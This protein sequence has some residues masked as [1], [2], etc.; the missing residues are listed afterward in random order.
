MKKILSAMLS[1][2][3]LLCVAACDN[4]P[5]GTSSEENPSEETSS[6][7]TLNIEIKDHDGDGVIRVSCVGDSITAGSGNSTYPRFLGDYLKYHGESVDGKTYEVKNHG[8]GGAAVRRD[9]PDA[10][11]EFWYDSEQYNGSLTYNSDVVIVQMGTNDGAYENLANADNYFKD[12]YKAMIKPY[13]DRNVTVVLA[14]PPEAS[15][16]IHNDGVNGKIST[17]VREIAEELK[18]PLVDMNVLTAGR[19]ESFPDGLHGN[20]S[21]YSLIAQMYYKHVF[22]GKLVTATINTQAGATVE[23][24]IN[25]AVANEQGVAK[26]TMIDQVWSRN[27][28]IEITC[29]GY[30]TINDSII[31]NSSASFNFPMTQGMYNVTGDAS[32]TADSAKGE[33][34]AQKAIDGDLSTRWESE[35]HDNA[36]LTVDL[37]EVKKINGVNIVWEG[38]YA[39]EYS[40]EVSIDGVSFTKVADETLAREG[41]KSTAFD[42]TDARYIK[43]NCK[44]RANTKFGSSIKE[45]S[46]LSDYAE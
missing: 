42:E 43:V 6:E 12:H 45:I 23:I 27:Y 11:D 40:V 14:T 35:Y 2:A 26:I 18:L 21:G 44:K 31:I 7:E 17:L 10:N 9:Q 19:E 33:N 28:E 46:I 8:L 20:D 13:L 37:G 25:M 15:N 5:T 38:A 16:G 34:I 32:A 22:G 29:E 41:L 24:D 3:M 1:I 30:K 39:S 36:W 4:T